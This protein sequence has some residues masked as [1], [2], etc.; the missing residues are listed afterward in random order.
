MSSPRERAL[1]AVVLVLLAA[2]ATWF[3]TGGA[4]GARRVSIDT[5]GGAGTSPRGTERI[6][7]GSRTTLD[8]ARTVDTDGVEFADDV[9]VARRAEPTGR[10][11][12]ASVRG[13]V[14]DG[15]GDGVPEIEVRMLRGSAELR[16]TTDTA[17]AF[18]FPEV[19]RGVQRFIVDPRSL[20]AG[21]LP[22]RSQHLSRP[23]AGAPDG[24]SGTSLRITDDDEH[25]V[26]LR[27]FRSGSVRGR[28]VDGEG[29]PVPR[30]A[31]VLRGDGGAR[32]AA[33][34]DAEGR[35]R[36]DA[37]Y[38]GDYVA[39]VD[40]PDGER[41]LPL[42][43]TVDPGGAVAVPDLVVGV[44]GQ[45]VTGRVVDADG[46]S[47]AGAPVVLEP[48]SV[49]GPAPR[50]ECTTDDDGAFR[51]GR[52]PVGDYRLEVRDAARGEGVQRFA[53]PAEPVALALFRT[54]RSSTSVR[55]SW[56]TS[57]RSSWS[58]TSSSVQASTART[59]DPARA[60]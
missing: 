25:E 22:P 7:A 18:L 2:G 27:V 55:S 37:A 48:V 34:T 13:R 10:A 31:V 40:V 39:E 4:E 46:A 60:T 9:S 24:S 52:A 1:L 56:R 44:G 51:M 30:V 57:T 50:L 5:V 21:L 53:A 14:V 26:E 11:A 32:S 54:P 43:V 33:R 19:E 12:S 59:C 42:D 20:P 49:S 29:R 28:V 3:L 15:A 16:A 38:P 6:A 17:G 23:Y 41:P 45:V 35:Y 36:I 58:S 8:G 47:I